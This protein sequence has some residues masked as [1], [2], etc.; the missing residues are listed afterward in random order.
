MAKKKRYRARKAAVF[1]LD[2]F[3]DFDPFGI[4]EKDRHPWYIGK[5]R[6]QGIK[7]WGEGKKGG[8]EAMPR[9]LIRVYGLSLT[10]TGHEIAR[11]STL[12]E[13]KEYAKVRGIGQYYVTGPYAMPQL[14]TR[15]PIK[16]TMHRRKRGE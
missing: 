6:W 7:A 14:P 9:D 3:A 4:P 8:G 16:I 5:K 1:L 11:F 2:P 15:G 12:D 10:P 13:L